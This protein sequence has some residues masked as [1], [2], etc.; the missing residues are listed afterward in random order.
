MTMAPGEARYEAKHVS[1]KQ[2]CGVGFGWT[3]QEAV[4]LPRETLPWTQS[5]M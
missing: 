5:V 4:L 2:W 1:E 3:D